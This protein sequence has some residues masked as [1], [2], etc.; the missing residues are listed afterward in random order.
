MLRILLRD[1]S[2][3]ILTSSIWE[4][5]IPLT[6]GLFADQCYLLTPPAQGLWV[7]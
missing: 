5:P 1:L 2:N 7:M 3:H 4:L 6:Y